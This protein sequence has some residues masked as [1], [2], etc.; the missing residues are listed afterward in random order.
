MCY[1]GDLSFVLIRIRISITIYHESIAKFYM[2]FY[3]YF[4]IIH[5]L[6]FRFKCSTHP[7]SLSRIQNSLNTSGNLMLRLHISYIVI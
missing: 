6:T 2:I 1:F 7:L 5:E 4:I 3:V